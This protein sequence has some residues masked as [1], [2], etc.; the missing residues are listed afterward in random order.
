MVANPAKFKYP[1]EHYDAVIVGAGFAGMYMLHRLRQAGYRARVFEAADDV[2]GTWY[3]NRY[4]GARC[5][6]ESLSYSFSFSP[7]LEQKWEWTER[8]AP[9]PE[10]LAYARHVSD[11]FDLRKDIRFNTRVE[12]AE[13]IEADNRWRIK[14]DQEDVTESRFCIMAT[15][16]L[17][18]PQLPDIPGLDNFA[19]N[20]YQA[21][22]WP[23]EPVSF[24]GQRVGVIGTGSS[25]IQAIPVIARQ[26]DH[27]TVFQRTPNFSVPAMNAPLDPAWV[28]AFKQNYREH[29]RSHKL[30]IEGGFGDLQIEPITEPPEMIMQADLTAAEATAILEA[31]WQHGGA[32]FIG[33]MADLMIDE[34]ANRFATRFVHRKIHEIVA[35]PATAELLCP[36]EYPIGSRRIC[37]DSDYYATYNRNNVRPVSVRDHPIQE[38]QTNGIQLDNDF[39]PFDTLVLATGF[40]AMTGALLRM[41]I[42]GESGQKLQDKWHAGPRT[43][44]G[45]MVSG[46]P[47]LFTITGPG[48]PSVISNVLVSIEQ[49]VDWI[50]DCL[51]YMDDSR[52][53]KIIVKPDAEEGWVAHVNEVANATLYP[54]GGSWYLGANVKGK[55]RIF[56]PYAGGVGPYREICEEIKADN[57][58]GFAFA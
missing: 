36:T 44:L 39:V 8:Y 26:A 56:M 45:L 22:T 18:V 24:D 50:M 53:R 27:L 33:V 20:R 2:G 30:G 15:G 11:R 32:Y 42:R 49:H 3:W 23:H 55:P 57:Y 5:D 12:S 10:I 9:Q 40:D 35:D 52:H 46:F 19:G 28:E 43:Y 16:C 31:A 48:S 17:S 13:Y 29:R 37:V 7:E 25:G 51:A 4:P 34:E 47:N 58:R 21:S 14:T 54:K 41:D 1:A 6:A 38:I